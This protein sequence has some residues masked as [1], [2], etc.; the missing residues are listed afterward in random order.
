MGI[1]GAVIGLKGYSHQDRQQEKY[2]EF[3]QR[4]KEMRIGI[5]PPKGNRGYF[6]KKIMTFNNSVGYANIDAKKM[7]CNLVVR[8]QWL[9]DVSW[10][11][12]LCLNDIKDREISDRVVDY[13]LNGK[14]EYI[15]YLGKNDH[16]AEISNPQIVECDTIELP[17]MIDSLFYYDKVVLDDDPI[18]MEDLPFLFK[19][20]MPVKLNEFNNKYE[21]REV[22]YTNRAIEDIKDIL[23]VNHEG[24]NIALI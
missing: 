8:E 9:E 19:D 23:V 4:L 12:Y 21:F 18:D 14:S 17:E 20:Y 3:Y 24:L 16:F 15:P 5:I 7:P 2:P 6:S 22:A 11:I 10:D 13:L 1:I